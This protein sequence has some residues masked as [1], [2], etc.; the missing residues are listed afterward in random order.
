MVIPTCSAEDLIVYKLVAGRPQDLIDVEGIVRR[1]RDRLDVA[2]IREW[3][4]QFA[5]LKEDPNL[6]QP[7][8]AALL[9]K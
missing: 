8:E 3:G 1:Q 4:R 9:R 6:L 5:E 2:R 7:F